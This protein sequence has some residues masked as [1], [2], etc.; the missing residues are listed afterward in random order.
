MFAGGWRRG[1]PI[2]AL[3]MRSATVSSGRD[4]AASREATDVL[5][6]PKL[7]KIDIRNWSAYEPAVDAG[8]RAMNEALEKLDQP[9][10]EMRRR[11]SLAER[12]VA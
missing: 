1:P 11:P 10:S 9:L 5:V 7:E 2:V 12:K 3:L 4:L 8:E 6:T